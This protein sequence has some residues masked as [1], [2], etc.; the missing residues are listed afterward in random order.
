MSG[1]YPSRAHTKKLLSVG[2]EKREKLLLNFHSLYHL[3]LRNR[4]KQILYENKETDFC[5]FLYTDCHWE[6]FK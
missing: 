2:D 5:F 3:I 4:R 6:I 1:V